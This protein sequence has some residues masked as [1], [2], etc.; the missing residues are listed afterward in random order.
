MDSLAGALTTEVLSADT[1]FEQLKGEWDRLLDA[2][3]QRVYFLRW[4][5]NRTWWKYYAPLGS[6]LYLITCR[7]D[8]GQL[9]GLAPLYWRRLRVLGLL[10]TRELLFLGMGTGLKTSEYLDI[11]AR[12][13]QEARVAEAITSALSQRSDWDRLWLWEVPALSSVLPH[14]AHAFGQLATTAVCDRAPYIDTST[15]WALFKSSFGRSMRRNVEYYARRL[16]KKH[17]CEFSRVKSHEALGPAMDALVRLHQWSWNARGYPGAFSDPRFNKFV[18]QAVR[19][20]HDEGRLRLWTLKVDGVIEAV[21]LG[22]LDNGVLHYFQKG[23]NPDYAKEDIGTAMLGLC[24]RDCFDDPD[25]QIFD[26]MGGVVAY[27]TLWAPSSRAQVVCEVSRRTLGAS[28]FRMRR[29]LGKVWSGAY[30]ALAP[31][32]LRSARQEWLRR[33]RVR[34]TVAAATQK[35]AWSVATGRDR[36][37]PE[38]SGTPNRSPREP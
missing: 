37:Q 10:H 21:L 33:R 31:E 2:S 3:A 9:V 17:A 14:F 23:V 13:G 25:V 18:W 8:Q 5:W 7:D 20:G 28:A 6:R 22:F 1:A 32:A 27:K 4:D 19:T 30:R 35:P 12:Q 38:P 34:R 24:V 26:F 11:V 15:S 36:D 16:F 29:W